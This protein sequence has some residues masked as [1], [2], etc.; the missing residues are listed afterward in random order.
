VAERS[1]AI[2]VALLAAWALLAP[3]ARPRALAI[4]GALVA[5]P[6]LLLAEVWDSAAFATLRHHPAVVVGGGLI[7]VAA[8]VVAGALLARRWPGIVIVAAVI[9]LPFRI[10]VTIG[11]QT[12][13]LLLP[14]YVVIAAG[15][16]AYVLPRLRPGHPEERQAPGPIEWTLAGS[17]V[18]YALQATYTSDFSQ[19]AQQLAFFYVPFALLFALMA[20]IVWSTRLVRDC[21]AAFAGLAL[22]FAAVG[23]VELA[24]HGVLWNAKLEQSNAYNAYFRV[25]SL[26]FDP[27]IY[28]RFLVVVMSFAAVAV[29]YARTFRAGRRPLALLIVLWFALLTTLSQS[30]LGA[31]LAALGLIVAVCGYARLIAALAAGVALLAVLLV[32]AAP[33]ALHLPSDDV[34]SLRKATSGRSTLVSGGADLISERPVLGFGSG[35][36]AKEYQ[37]LH[38]NPSTNDVSASHTTPITIAAEQG[39]PGVAM[40]LALLVSAFWVMLSGARASPVRVAIAAAFVALVFHTFVYAAFLEDPLAWG[41]LAAGAALARRPLEVTERESAGVRQAPALAG[42]AP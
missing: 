3:T 1:G 9:A 27:N 25:N 20:R 42:G 29:A 5:T 13:N 7:A 34:G 19:A 39:V 14:L 18:L 22:L 15:G 11:G 36:F 6:I 32:V 24:V 35:S 33:G 37:R 28:G 31:L 40:Y 8:V 2:V 38:G 21:A 4:A 17:L 26:F 23:F 10:P 30:S 12:A 41:L 16:V